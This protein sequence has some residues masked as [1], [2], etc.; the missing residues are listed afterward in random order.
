MLEASREQT[1][2]VG[3]E[4]LGSEHGLRGEE[5]WQGLPR[6]FSGPPLPL[7]IPDGWSRCSVVSSVTLALGPDCGISCD[8]HG[9]SYHHSRDTRS[10]ASQ[11]PRGPGDAGG[12]P[13]AEVSVWPD[14]F[15]ACPSLQPAPSYPTVSCVSQGG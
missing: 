7:S 2:G 11:F 1:R 5:G 8:G 9:R 6:D 14:V 15:Q 4:G 3:E 10:E 13:R 12:D